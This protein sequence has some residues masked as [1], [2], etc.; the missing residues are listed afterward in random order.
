MSNGGARKVKNNKL[1]KKNYKNGLNLTKE[2]NKLNKGM[3]VG[4]LVTQE[5]ERPRY[6]AGME[7]QNI[8]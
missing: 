5:K 1:K 4:W 7:M 6:T 3:S 2:S 8:I